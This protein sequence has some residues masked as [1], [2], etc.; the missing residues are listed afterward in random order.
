MK[1][2]NLP[3]CSVYI[4]ISLDGFIARKNG[5]INWLVEAT[6]EVPHGEDFGYHEFMESVDLLLMGRKTYEKVLTFPEWP[7]KDKKVMVMS[8]KGIELPSN[9]TDKVSVTSASPL[10]ILQSLENKNIKRIYVDG[11]ITIQSFLKEGL[12]DDLIITQIPIII[13]TGIPLFGE[14][15][16]DIK[17]EL[18]ESKAYS[19]GFIKSN[20]KL[21]KS[22]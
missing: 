20:Y 15:E 13:G 10:E 9:L 6:A 7:Y 1:D 16:K 22:V 5:S 2:K 8:K 12:I 4:A 3:Q 11:G 19:C 14:I 21:I 18:V 17:L